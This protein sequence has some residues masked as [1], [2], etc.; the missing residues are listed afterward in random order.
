MI[1]TPFYLKPFTCSFQGCFI[2]SNYL[3]IF[4]SVEKMFDKAEKEGKKEKC[5]DTRHIS[6]M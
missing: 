3:Y 4:D 1:N 2:S 6:L 5:T